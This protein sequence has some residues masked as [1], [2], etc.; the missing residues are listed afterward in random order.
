[1][2][3]TS[4]SLRYGAALFGAVVLTC[5]GTATANADLVDDNA[6]DIHVEIDEIDTGFLALTVAT[7]STDLEEVASADPLLRQFE[8]ALPTVTVTDTRTSAPP[9]GATWAVLGSASDFEK[10]DDPTVTIGAEHLGWEP[11]LLDDYG[12]AIDAGEPTV[13]VVDD[14]DSVGLSAVDTEIL[15]MNWDQGETVGEGPWS[16]TADLTLKVS[17]AGIHPGSYTSVLTLSLFE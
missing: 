10:D 3:S 17:A 8:G 16:A 6:V 13:G 7:P 12:P 14:A 15:Y 9:A 2:K 11:R 1:M 4:R 5:A